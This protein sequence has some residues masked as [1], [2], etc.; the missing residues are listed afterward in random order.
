MKFPFT[1]NF[2]E[3]WEK[4]GPS[5]NKVI[6]KPFGKGIVRE[7]TSIYCISSFMVSLNTEYI[8]A[9]MLT[10]ENGMP[11][12]TQVHHPRRKAA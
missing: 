3:L 12:A 10:S 9:Q 5:L 1:I 2:P 4:K 11:S 7:L 8:A 6:E